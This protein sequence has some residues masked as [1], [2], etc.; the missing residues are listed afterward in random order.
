M[1]TSFAAALTDFGM[2][3]QE[4]EVP[5]TGLQNMHR[6]VNNRYLEGGEG[7]REE[8]EGRGRRGEEG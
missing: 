2:K 3:I 1:N 6:D 7:G 5:H 4:P 8:E